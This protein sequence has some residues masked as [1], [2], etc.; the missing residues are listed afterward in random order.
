MNPLRYLP[1]AQSLLEDF[2]QF[3]D[4]LEEL[5][6][7]TEK[8]LKAMEK[9]NENKLNKELVQLLALND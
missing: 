8:K 5:Q 4:Q 2:N 9:V 7:N 1:T 3:D 6:A